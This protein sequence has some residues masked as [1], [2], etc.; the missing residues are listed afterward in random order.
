MK[1]QTLAA[2]AAGLVLGSAGAI[3]YR[4][5]AGDRKTPE[6]KT[7]LECAVLTP[8]YNEG[9]RDKEMG[10]GK[11]AGYERL[12]GGPL[13]EALKSAPATDVV[14]FAGYRDGISFHDSSGKFVVARSP[15]RPLLLFL[16]QVT[17]ETGR[18]VFCAIDDQHMK[19]IEDE[20]LWNRV[21]K[22]AEME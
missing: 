15:V 17:R 10:W 2:L 14:T 18:Y 13:L 19:Y 5:L 20:A 12:D 1:Y 3:L 7:G 11:L 9:G 6:P 16:T 4:H 22:I 21:G 8:V